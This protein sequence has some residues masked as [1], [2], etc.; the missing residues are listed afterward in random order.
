MANKRTLT[1]R[2]AAWKALNTSDIRRH[3]TADVLNQLLDRTDRAAQAMDIVMGVV[4]LQGTIDRVLKQCADID[5]D[6][7]KKSQWNLLRMGVYEL[8]YCPRTAE[9]AILNE[10]TELAHRGGSK[11]AAGFVNAVLRNVQRA[12]E[13]RQAPLEPDTL[14]RMIPQDREYGCL[15]KQTLLAGFESQPEQ[16]LSQAYSM[17]QALVH[18]WA[19]AYGIERAKEICIASN[20]HPSVILQPNVLKTKIIE[21]D[22][23]RQL[24]EGLAYVQDTAASRAIELLGPEPGWTVLDLCSAPGGKAAAMAMRMRDE[25]KILASD[26]DPKRLERVRE[27][28]KRLGLRC[29]E[30]VQAEQ[31]EEAAQKCQRLDAIALDVPC[32]NTGVLAR[33]VEAR[34]RWSQK[35]MEQLVQTQRQLLE[36]AAALARADTRILYSTCS[37][38]PQ[39][40]EQQVERLLEKHRNFK[41][42]K[43]QLTFPATQ[44]G[45]AIDHDGGFAAVLRQD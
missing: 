28:A 25:G 3:D 18:S 17:P 9:Y 44:T 34:W 21:V 6:R 19:A 7:V 16:Y 20:R 22:H 36:Q 24:L 41:L 29:V 43:Q 14:S 38:Q 40:N 5:T 2:Q 31:V 11:K 42:E 33:R 37:I 13:L 45:E 39:E 12:I 23:R 8:V 27:M 4:R 35:E 1:A 30:V 26:I 15:F 32:S 10:T